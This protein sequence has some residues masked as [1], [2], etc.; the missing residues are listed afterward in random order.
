MLLFFGLFDICIVCFG[1]PNAATR[2]RS[3]N[4]GYSK[5]DIA[6]YCSGGVMHYCES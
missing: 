6:G 3:I 5:L 1:F 2:P 4:V